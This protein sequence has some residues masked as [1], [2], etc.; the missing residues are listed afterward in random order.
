MLIAKTISPAAAYN[1]LALPS[2][3]SAGISRPW[4]LSRGFVLCKMAAIF[5]AAV[6]LSSCGTGQ[7]E[8]KPVSVAEA[9]PAAP[10]I[11]PDVEAA[12]REF[13]G[14][15][16]QVLAFGDLAKTGAQQVLAANMVPRTP[17]NANLP[18][19][20]ATRTSIAENIDGK[21]TEIF[22]CDEH[23]KNSKG[24]LGRTP[25]SPVTGWRVQFEQDAQKGLQ[26]YFTP[27]GKGSNQHVLPIG[28]RWNPAVKRYQTLDTSYEHCFTESPSLDTP[29]SSLR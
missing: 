26:L 11:P 13:L 6:L 5:S 14:S 25:L 9:K 27:L 7:T 15:E 16:A 29:R 28:V 22:R 2:L 17:A 4:R 20:I 3:Q 10:T 24:Y 18:G 8:S 1:P 12:A 21:W 19:P 23:L